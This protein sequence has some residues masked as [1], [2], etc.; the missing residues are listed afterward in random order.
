MNSSQVIGEQAENIHLN[1]Q[2][3]SPTS[4]PSQIKTRLC[5]DIVAKY[6]QK[7]Y[8]FIRYY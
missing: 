3:F 4:E 1:N 6:R 7:L 5:P 8:I 2:Q